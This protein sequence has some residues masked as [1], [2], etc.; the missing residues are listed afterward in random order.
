[1]YYI[2][3]KSNY[4]FI[5]SSPFSEKLEIKVLYPQLSEIKFLCPPL[6]KKLLKSI[7]TCLAIY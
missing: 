2:P 1:M 3:Q 7:I 6:R 4:V 5:P